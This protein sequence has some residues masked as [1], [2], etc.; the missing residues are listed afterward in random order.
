MTY[1]NIL[2][3]L[4]SRFPFLER[5]YLEEG[6]YIFGIAHPSLSIVFVPYIREIVEKN[7]VGAI[8]QVSEFL[9]DMAI[10]KDEKVSELM[11][12]SVLENILSERE[13][14]KTL[15]TYLKPKTAEWLLCLEKE[16]GWD[17]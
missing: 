11:V 1:I 6:Y 3:V 7:D 14:L 10:C 16:Y 13:L 5:K 2:T 9:E 4:F 12:V 15:K 8:A 17:Y